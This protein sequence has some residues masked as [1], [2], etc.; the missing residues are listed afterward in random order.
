MQLHIKL[1]QHRNIIMCVSVYISICT[2]L[3]VYYL[4]ACVGW[5]YCLDIFCM[6]DGQVATPDFDDGEGGGG[7][8][9]LQS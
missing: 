3:A 9:Q 2:H 6:E 7:G 8:I 5:K 4:S 1:L